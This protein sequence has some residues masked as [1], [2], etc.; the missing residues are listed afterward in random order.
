MA[1]IQ[2][3]CKWYIAIVDNI[4]RRANKWLIGNRNTCFINN[5]HVFTSKYRGM[6]TELF[7]IELFLHLNLCKQMSDIQLNCKWYIAIVENIKRRANKWLIVNR[8]TCFINNLHVFTSNYRGMLTEL[9]EIEMFL[10]LNLSKQMADIQLNCKWY[11]AIVDNIKRRANKWLKVNRNT[12]FSVE[13]TES[14]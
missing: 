3:N 1:D 4:K 7:E 6:L 13:I 11:I 12:F 2:L 9:F 8:N 5:L 10:H 14:N